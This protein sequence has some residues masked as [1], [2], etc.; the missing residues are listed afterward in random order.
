MPFQIDVII[1][2]RILHDQHFPGY[3]VFLYIDIPT[4][5]IY[6]NVLHLKITKEENVAD[7][8]RYSS[9]MIKALETHTLTTNPT[10]E[11]KV[12]SLLTA[13]I[14]FNIERENNKNIIYTVVNK[15]SG[16]EEKAQFTISNLVK[17]DEMILKNDPLTRIRYRIE[18]D[19]SNRAQYDFQYRVMDDDIKAEEN[20][21]LTMINSNDD[22]IVISA[23]SFKVTTDVSPNCR[24]AENAFK[25]YIKD[26]QLVI[27]FSTFLNASGCGG[28]LSNVVFNLYNVADELIPQRIE[29]DSNSI[30]PTFTKTENNFVEI[31]F[32]RV[33]LGSTIKMTVIYDANKNAYYDTFKPITVLHEMIYNSYVDDVKKEIFETKKLETFISNTGK[34]AYIILRNDSNLCVDGVS[35]DTTNEE[36]HLHVR[37]KCNTKF[38]LTQH[39]ILTEERKMIDGEN[40]ELEIKIA[41]YN[42]VKNV[43]WEE[44]DI[45]TFTT[46]EYFN[47]LSSQNGNEVFKE[48]SK[49][50]AFKREPTSSF[51]LVTNRNET[52]ENIDYNT[53]I[54]V[55][56]LDNVILF[57]HYEST[58]GTSECYIRETLSPT[59]RDFSRMFRKLDGCNITSCYGIDI[60]GNHLLYYDGKHYTI[61]KS[62]YETLVTS[63]AYVAAVKTLLDT[64][65]NGP[66]TIT[67][68]L[69]VAYYELYSTP[70]AQL[71]LWKK[72]ND[73]E[74]KVAQSAEVA[75][76]SC[77]E[78]KNYCKEA[79]SGKYWLDIIG[80]I[81]HVNCDMDTDRGGWLM[82]ANIERK[83]GQVLPAIESYVLKE[84]LET[85][86]SYY[87]DYWGVTYLYDDWAYT[88]I[89]LY[90]ITDNP[91][92]TSHIRTTDAQP[93]YDVINHIYYPTTLAT[94]SACPSY[95]VYNNDNSKSLSNCSL[96]DWGTHYSWYDEFPRRIKAN[97]ENMWSIEMGLCDQSSAVYQNAVW[98]I[99]VR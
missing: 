84:F 17:K 62:N 56:E 37:N 19:T 57:C 87:P 79:K 96:W 94:P 98:K 7:A 49:T 10:N 90:C 45:K 24:L 67:D 42:N 83:G 46:H 59:G 82:I 34:G 77:E 9:F 36:N 85:P 11:L 97:G 14:A 27:T 28:D 13:T 55:V 48:A 35:D 22:N 31:I 58:D 41:D 29:I 12:G 51:G 40:N 80:N 68:K 99:F 61:K 86:K 72:E 21:F 93:G 71:V 60:Y 26:N 76:G 66:E 70:Y 16:F 44:Y 78:V 69:S 32:G 65:Y 39:N 91:G 50:S 88:Q 92:R 43:E 89:R 18:D 23:K 74:K 3:D 73:C 33:Y 64:L 8:A 47:S 54:S 1:T 95:R 5:I 30:S 53:E 75:F 2:F 20:V 15:S 52:K 25:Q 4:E 6:Q 63:G 38:R 81:Y